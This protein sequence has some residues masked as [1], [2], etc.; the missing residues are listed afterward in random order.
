TVIR[1]SWKS[2]RL[3]QF[4]PIAPGTQP[5]ACHDN[6]AGNGSGNIGKGTLPG[7]KGGGGA[8]AADEE[9]LFFFAS[10]ASDVVA[11]SGIG[12]SL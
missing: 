2:V 10:A 3:V 7:M 11:N 9:L 5:S 8:Q 4:P 6:G 1:A 12:I